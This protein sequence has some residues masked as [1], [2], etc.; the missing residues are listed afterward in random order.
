MI[1]ATV[2]TQL[3]GFNYCY[4][5]LMI[6]F[7]IDHVCTQRSGYKYCYLTLIILFSTIHL[8]AHSQMILST[9]I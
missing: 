5:P 1:I 3:N 6:Q 2:S 9:I 4:Q 8:F 7:N